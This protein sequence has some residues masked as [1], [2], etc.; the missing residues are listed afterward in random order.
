V[1][2]QFEGEG[3]KVYDNDKGGK[4]NDEFMP[5]IKEFNQDQGGDF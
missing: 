1:K 4:G 5:K 2:S 3:N